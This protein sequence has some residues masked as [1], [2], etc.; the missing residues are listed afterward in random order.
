MAK[1]QVLGTRRRADRIGL[2]EAERVIARAQRGRRKQAADDRE[3]AKV[4]EAGPTQF[5]RAISTA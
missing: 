1:G 5:A 4:I 2:D 3:P